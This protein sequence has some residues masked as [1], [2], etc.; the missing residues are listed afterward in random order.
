MSNPSKQ[1]GT[2][3]ETAVVNYLNA[4]AI[5][6]RRNPPAGSKDV[7]DLSTEDG[8]WIVECKSTRSIDLAQ[9]C[10]ELV[11]EQLNA[12]RVKHA[13]GALRSPRGVAVI[14]RR[15]KSIGDAYA[16]M[17]LRLFADLIIDLEGYDEDG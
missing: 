9:A 4:L 15:R 12:A 16:V 8:A 14:K 10:D 13:G 17:P 1:R 5:P 7:G 11:T 6:A 2:A 3:F